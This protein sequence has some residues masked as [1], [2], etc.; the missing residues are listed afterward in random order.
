[1]LVFLLFLCVND[2][3]TALL[4]PQER[5]SEEA[6]GFCAELLAVL[7][8]SSDWLFIFKSSEPSI[9][10]PVTMVTSDDFTKL[11]PWAFCSLLLLQSAELLQRAV[12]RS[13][14]L[15]TAIVCYLSVLQLFLEGPTP[16]T[17]SSKAEPSH[18]LSRTKQFLLRAVSQTSP[19]ALS[20]GQLRQLESQCAELDPELAAALSVQ[21]E[22]PSLSPEMDFL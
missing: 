13:E 6:S 19:T 15:H 3:L 20:A 9:Y 7:V 16:S 11:V 10:Q 18:I 12:R 22:P 17:E 8:D 2:Y 21:L 1:M 4:Y 14:F 5:S